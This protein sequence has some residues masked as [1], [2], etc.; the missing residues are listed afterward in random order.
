M[1]ATYSPEHMARIAWMMA[2][3]KDVPIGKVLRNAGRDF[4]MEAYRSTPTAAV[5]RTNFLRVPDTRPGGRWRWVRRAKVRRPG[6]RGGRTP[7]PPYPV[8]KGFARATWIG[9]FRDLGMTTRRPAR[10][11]PP[12]AVELG[13]ATERPREV[14]IRDV[15]SYIGK[16]DARGGIAYR[17]MLKAQQT[18]ERELERQ[19]ERMRA[20]WT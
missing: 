11:V 12:A 19:A 17:G 20:M 10:Y 14:V 7:N 1:R 6:S 3:V 16:L 4:G 5:T 8:A 15:L 18:A 13:E 2:H 9:V